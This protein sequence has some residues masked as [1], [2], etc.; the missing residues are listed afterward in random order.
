E[1]KAFSQ[2]RLTRDSDLEVD[3]DDV[4]DLREA[5]RSK[6]TT[7]QFGQSVRLEVVRSC[8]ADLSDFLL[9]QFSLPPQALFMVNG[10]VNLVRLT[11]LI[12]QADAD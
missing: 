6:M 2:F 8:P 7:R 5:L 12:D 9:E 3:E 4:T 11:Q 1:I 10:P